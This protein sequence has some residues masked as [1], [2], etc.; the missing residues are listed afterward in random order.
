MGV[1]EIKE[2]VTDLFVKGKIND[3]SNDLLEPRISEYMDK[4]NE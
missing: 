2:K 1:G 4:M 3:S